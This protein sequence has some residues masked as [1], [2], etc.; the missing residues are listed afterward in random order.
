MKKVI[1]RIAE[2]V[3]DRPNKILPRKKLKAFRLT[4]KVWS[5]DGRSLNTYDEI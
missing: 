2:E 4:L 3:E 5:I 1:A